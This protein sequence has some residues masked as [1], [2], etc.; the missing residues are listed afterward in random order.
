MATAQRGHALKQQRI[1]FAQA[2][3]NPESHY[4]IITTGPHYALCHALRAVPLLQEYKGDENHRQV[5]KKKGD[6]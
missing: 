1:A 2:V 6:R 4:L 3:A 5:T